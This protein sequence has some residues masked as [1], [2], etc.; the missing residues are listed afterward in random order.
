MVKVICEYIHDGGMTD[1]LVSKELHHIA[2]NLCGL[3]FDELENAI[4]EINHG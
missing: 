2:K 3:W 1:N 4:E